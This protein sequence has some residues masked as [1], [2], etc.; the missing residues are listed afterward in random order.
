MLKAKV[1]KRF[2]VEQKS[3]GEWFRRKIVKTLVFSGINLYEGGSLT[4]YKDILSAFV[5][6][7]YLSEYHVTAFVHKKELFRE[8]CSTNIYFIELPDS[9]KNHMMRL[10]Y[11]YVWFYRYSL[12]NTIDIWISMHDITPNVR[13]DRLYTY[14]HNPTP[15][16][17][18]NKEIRKFD[19]TVYFMTKFYKYL[20][21]I[22][23]HRNAAVIVQQ[24]W[25]RTEFQK[26]Y[27]INHAIVARPVKEN[28]RVQ[29]EECKGGKRKV[30]IFPAFARPFKNHKVICEAVKKLEQRKL[31]CEVLF[32]ING[33]ENQYA[34]YLR[35]HYGQLSMIKWIGVQPRETMSKLY[36]YSDCLLFPS[37][38]ETWGLPI[39]E[40]KNTGKA[41][42]LADL[43]YAHET[44]GTYDNAIFFE[45]DSAEEL[46]DKMEAVANGTCV[47]KPQK[48]KKVSKPYAADWDELLKYILE[49]NG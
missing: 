33:N 44:L 15:F 6:G 4:I 22:N 32:T 18:E 28:V 8:F 46:A 24:E 38:L 23:I 34:E 39:S 21:R 36:A 16:C 12:E 10:Y 27:H 14:C 42:L 40:Y 2:D 25:I 26:M 19:K 37:L 41:I 5:Q 17:T 31:D 45:P 43:P 47:Y 7:G 30:F 29:I 13:S 9:R 1:V 11:E 35:R 3:G 49:G 48:E 20:Y